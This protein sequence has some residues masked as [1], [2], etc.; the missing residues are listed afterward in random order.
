MTRET[1]SGTMVRKRSLVYVRGD[2]TCTDG[3]PSFWKFANIKSVDGVADGDRVQFTADVDHW[4]N[5]NGHS[6][7]GTCRRVRDVVVE[8]VAEII[9]LALPAIATSP[10]ADWH[11]PGEKDESDP[12][13]A[14]SILRTDAIREARASVAA[15]IRAT[16]ITSYEGERVTETDNDPNRAEVWAWMQ[17]ERLRIAA[18]IEAEYGLGD[19]SGCWEGDE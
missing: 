16:A 15:L 5:G 13:P 17:E 3:T 10:D 7:G 9:P 19:M 18:Q 2:T 1:L 11:E 12:D 8:P 4:D 6:L 14:P